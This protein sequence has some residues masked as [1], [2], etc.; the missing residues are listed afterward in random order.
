MR[1][2]VGATWLTQIV[3]TFILLFA[4]IICYAVNYGKAF[5]VKNQILEDIESAGSPIGASNNISNYLSNVGYRKSFEL[6][7]EEKNGAECH[8]FGINGKEADNVKENGY[9]HVCKYKVSDNSC[10][11]DICKV[12]Y[13]VY[14]AWGFDLPVLGGL[15]NFQMSG[16]TKQMDD[17]GENWYK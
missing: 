6:G 7:D 10:N 9:Y 11:G 4:A 3:I 14:V 1:E 5:K 8:A 13:K 2:S 15:L 16:T 17:V 12:Y